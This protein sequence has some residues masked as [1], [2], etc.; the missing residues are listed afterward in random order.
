[1]KKLKI[2]QITCVALFIIFIFF[3][4][5]SVDYTKEYEVDNIAITESYDKENNN[6]YFT[7]TYQDYTLDY[8]YESK[9]KHHRL[10]IESID[11]IE[12]EDDFCL[13]PHGDIID[14]IPLCVDNEEITYYQK[15]NDKLKEKIPKEYLQAKKE[16]NENEEDLTIYNDSYTY[17]L[18]DYDGFYY[19]N[20]DER[21]KIDL[22]D[23]EIY[24]ASLITYTKDYLVVAD[25]DSEYTFNKF[26]R[27]DLQSG[28]VKEFSLD[29][30]IYFDSYFP[31]YEK[32]KLYIV[33][34]KEEEMYELN[35]KNGKLKRISAKMLN[36]DEWEKVG[37][38]SLINSSKKFTYKSNYE[39]KLNENI[40]TLHYKDKKISTKIDDEVTHIV[41]IKD[42]LIFYLKTDTLYVF[43]PKEGSSRLLNN[44]E[45]NFKFENMIYVN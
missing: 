8:L 27:I 42:N 22:F 15:V 28:D 1:M 6:Y 30:N 12:D 2:F 9:Y 45:W 40:L 14:F 41:R 18:W 35:V 38:K 5:R 25:Y 21:K 43:N 24:N 10:F 34:N 20:S 39:Y 29:R 11:V 19:I 23:T 4:F 32:N 36:N 13:I 26:Y 33:D 31:G 7:L 3:F 37:I 16:L 44:F 17:L